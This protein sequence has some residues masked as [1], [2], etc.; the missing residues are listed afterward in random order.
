MK[1]FA[2]LVECER[3]S[4]TA[5]P[6]IRFCYGQNKRHLSALEHILRFV[7]QRQKNF[8]LATDNEGINFIARLWQEDHFELSRDVYWIQHVSSAIRSYQRDFPV[9][10]GVLGEYRPTLFSLVLKSSKINPC[11]HD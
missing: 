3:T 7:S 1:K 10:G 5:P 4:E 8:Y 6:I 2:Y 11:C 9:I